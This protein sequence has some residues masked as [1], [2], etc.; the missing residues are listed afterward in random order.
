MIE[1]IKTKIWLKVTVILAIIFF[2]FC[3]YWVFYL[4]WAHSTFDN[5][6]KFRGCVQF[7]GKNDTVGFCKLKNGST[8]KL[9]KFNG[10]WYLDGDLPNGKFLDF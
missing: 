9:V 2:A 4:R 3:L 5:Y 8:I 7:L 1:N 10:K 6:Y